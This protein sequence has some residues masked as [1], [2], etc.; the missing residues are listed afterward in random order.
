MTPFCT[1]PLWDWNYTWYSEYPRLTPCFESTVL[2]Y[3]P[4]TVLVSFAL[5]PCLVG[6]WQKQSLYCEPLSWTPLCLFK[7]VASLLLTLTYFISLAYRLVLG[8]YN[9]SSV[10]ADVVHIITFTITMLIQETDRKNGSG[11]SMGL[12]FFW[13][14]TVLCKFPECFRR[15]LEAF[16]SLGDPPDFQELEFYACVI[17]YPIVLLQFL[18]SC[19]T[20]VRQD[21]RRPYLTAPPVS[22][23]FFGWVSPLILRG[24]RRCLQVED[25][26]SIPQDMMT[27]RNHSKWSALW[28][29]ELRS[30]GYVAEAGSCDV[31]K[32]LPSMFKPIWKAYW[33]PL[34]ISVI[35]STLGAVLKIIPSLLLHLLLDFMVG[36][37][38]KWKGVLYS[39]GIVS[40]NFTSR[41]LGV[42]V[43]MILSFIGLNAKTV[44]VAAIYRKTLMLSS[45]SQI[46]YTLGDLVNLIF[47]DADR[48]YQLSVVSSY[49]VTGVPMIIIAVILLWQYLGVACLAGVAVMLVIMPIGALAV[50]IGNKYQAGHMKLKDKRLEV[51]AEML[52]SAKLLKLF[53]WENIFIDKCTTSRLKEM[54]FLKK[55]SCVTAVSTCILTCST[56]MVS[57]ASFVTYVLT[58]NDHVLDPSTAFVSMAL[59]NNMQYPIFIIPDIISKV[60]QTSVSMIRIRKF[61]LSSEVDDCSV[62]R[63]PDEGYAVSVRN[64]SLSW[65]KDKA[66]VLTNINL[67]VKKGQLV[68]VVGSVGSGKSTLL[69]AFLGNLRVFSG[70]VSC[71]ES[72]AYA[73][74]CPWIQNKT[75]RENV[76]FMGAFD[77]K[78][79]ELVLKACSLEKDLEILPC[80]DLTEIGERGINLSGGQKQRVSLARAAYQ[81]KELYLLDDPLS[82]V[83][84]H[85]GASLF[86]NLIGPQGLLKETTRILVT[87][88]F[89]MLNEV[90]YIFVLQ[91][92]SIVESGT[93]EG[94]KQEGSVFSRLL[95]NFS[96]KVKKL[97]ENEDL[98]AY[99]DTATVLEKKGLEATFVKREITKEGSISLQVYRTYIRYAGPSLIIVVLCYAIYIAL[100]TYIAIW[101]CEWTNDSLFFNGNQYISKQRY[102]IEVYILLCA[103]QAIATFLAVISLWRVALTASTRLHEST[104]HGVMRAPLSFFETNPSGRL[105]NR[106]SK[107]VDQLDLQLP[108]AGHNTLDLLFLLASSNLLVCI[109]IPMYILVV[110]AVM[111]FLFVLR[112]MFVALF[113]DVKRLETVSRS[114]VNSHFSETVAGLSSVRSYDVQG[115]FLRD[116]D[117]KID[118]MQTCTVNC[119]FVLYWIQVWLEIASEVLL[120]SMLLLLVHSRDNIGAGTAGL[121][122]SYSLNSLF[123]FTYFVL[124]STE[125]E[126]SLISAER[127]D[128]YSRLTPEAPWVSH[129]RPD[130][131][132]PASGA[133]SFKSY[134][135]RYRQGLDLTLRDVDLYVRPGEKIGIVGRTGAGKSTL[136]LSLFR[137]IEAAAGKI[138][139]DDVDIAALGLQDLR[140]R[141]TIIPQESFL[142]RGTLRFNL[143]P[144]GQHDAEELC[145]A[146]KKAHLGD[147]FRKG[148]G[149]D[150]EILDG[151]K[152]LSVGQRQLVCLARAVLRKAK[153]LV[154]DEATASVD[155]KTD[156]LVQQT[157]R[158]LMS[159]CTVLTIAHRLDTVLNSDRIVVLDQGR[160]IE[161]GSPAALLADSKS[162]FHAMAREAGVAESGL[163]AASADLAPTGQAESLA[164]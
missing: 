74:Q 11:S 89:S 92:G 91:E 44:M 78:L 43:D 24:P 32:P 6:R 77:A 102:R 57:F 48:L 139:V 9:G 39:L 21:T 83:D 138:V 93:F 137:I 113:R 42:H 62:G 8:A 149:L 164:G 82:A 104:L 130:P 155:M 105:L 12:F 136:A 94:L 162:S 36:T 60:V 159:G 3:T 128:E 140:S 146:L 76:L 133:V 73:P 53:A 157:L 110:A 46:N 31:S 99:Q 22:F 141:I 85:V 17:A 109:N 47:V 70:S 121:L 96:K 23:I 13:L 160:V 134:S 131:Q 7:F 72:V 154:L 45:E 64:A 88:N 55:Y 111:V 152:N 30:S 163:R 50:T 69:S 58:S 117:D 114:P 71:T 15:I 120:F 116:N 67:T 16:A 144:A 75:I 35:F 156:L 112:Q 153:I 81:K 123:A 86:K 51:V 56:A 151:G 52:S 158:D 98:L 143:D 125:F 4:A 10:T 127:L 122:V 5:V 148:G 103:V 126:A 28:R 29:K 19:V 84:A 1:V 124:Y 80:G 27:Q 100:D 66:P 20:D 37:D 14:L 115:I 68:A 119:L 26:Y 135:T 118:N 145:S 65:S 61:L 147:A 59:F 49:G 25:I 106:F 108:T 54:D 101:L 161:V 41:L 150:F 132:W 142:F 34:A 2:V 18:L 97:T 129:V 40:A 107:D 95:Q 33:K 38:P 79:Y 87:H 90:D 63:R